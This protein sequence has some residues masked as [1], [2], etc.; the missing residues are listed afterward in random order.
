M[1]ATSLMWL[2]KDEGV[3]LKQHLEVGIG[4]RNLQASSP[5]GFGARASEVA[6]SE[7]PT[8]MP[9][10]VAPR[11]AGH[12]WSHQIQ[13]FALTF[14]LGAFYLGDLLLSAFLELVPSQL[15]T[16]EWKYLP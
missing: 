15:Q 8:P 6:A 2:Q 9:P 10:S 5:S 14:V 4:G 3:A 13:I 11:N 1:K 16:W 12:K 7:T